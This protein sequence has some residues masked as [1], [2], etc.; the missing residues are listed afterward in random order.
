MAERSQRRKSARF[1]YISD[2]DA[3]SSWHDR[4]AGLIVRVGW[5][6]IAANNRPLGRSAEV[7]GSSAECAED[8]ARLRH[9]IE[10]LATS[11]LFDAAH[12]YW[13][14]AVALDGRAAAVCVNPYRRRVE[15]E[16]ALAQFLDAVRTT[17]PTVDEL[18][19][20]GPTALRAYDEAPK[21]PPDG[22]VTAVQM[23]AH[24]PRH[25]P[26]PLP[27]AIS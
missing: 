14:W 16:R 27:A 3:R 24:R 23:S 22:G 6:V 19:H 15:C 26:R 25:G 4:P 2:A 13:Q 21:L 18:R 17:D 9:G 5:R 8:A 11:V 20:Y 7:F 10:R 12:G 1:L